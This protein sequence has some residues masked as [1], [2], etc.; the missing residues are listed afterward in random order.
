MKIFLIVSLTFFLGGCSSH[1]E[2]WDSGANKQNTYQEQQ[3]Q[4]QTEYT[5]NQF[6]TPGASGVEQNQPF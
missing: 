1:S 5:R 3:A 2:R 4:E 6:Q